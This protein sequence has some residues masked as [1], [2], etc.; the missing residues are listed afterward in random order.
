MSIHHE[1]NILFSLVSSKS[2]N[3]KQKV[4]SWLCG[5]AFYRLKT[6]SYNK[7]IAN[8]YEM[9]SI[10]NSEIKNNPHSGITYSGVGYEPNYFQDVLFSNNGTQNNADGGAINLSISGALTNI[11]NCT[12]I[13]IM[14][15]YINV[16]VS[17]I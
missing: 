17:P 4:R 15:L 1:K 6:F 8:L 11:K 12:F 10:L 16:S 3:A 14:K 7:L 9:Y 13:F 2:R 5:S